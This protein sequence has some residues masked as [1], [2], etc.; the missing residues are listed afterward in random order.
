MGS[1]TKGNSMNVFKNKEAAQKEANEIIS[2]RDWEK[3]SIVVYRTWAAL[4]G[5]DGYILK[6]V[7]GERI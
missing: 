6:T 1:S 4:D 7:C 2:A 5:V 3:D